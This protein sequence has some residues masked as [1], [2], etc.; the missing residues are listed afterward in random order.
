MNYVSPPSDEEI[1]RSLYQ[2][3]R[4][5]AAVIGPAEIGPDDLLH[6]AIVAVLRRHHLSSLDDPAAYL[7]RAMVN[8][9]SNQRRGLGRR[10]R[11]YLRAVEDRSGE[12][13]EPA[14]YDHYPHDMA[15]LLSLEPRSRAVLYLREIE[16]AAYEDIAAQLGLTPS[17]ARQ[18][19]HRA[20]RALRLSE[21]AQV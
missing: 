20:L 21:E 15:I 10:R 17:N 4:R 16:G 3:L 6:D 7:R 9:A 2:S 19:Y 1:L 5:F 13:G 18:I 14:R 12:V 11:A 8:L